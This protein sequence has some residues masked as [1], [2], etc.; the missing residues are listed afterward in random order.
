MIPFFCR[1]RNLKPGD[2]VVIAGAG[3]VAQLAVVAAK[4]AG[5]G[6]VIL[7]G[8]THDRSVRFPAALALGADLVVDSLTEGC[9]R[10]FCAGTAPAE[11]RTPP[12]PHPG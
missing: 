6:K 7:S 3:Q 10:G 5:A 12:W 1:P 2:T 8:V 9:C 4:A 11:P